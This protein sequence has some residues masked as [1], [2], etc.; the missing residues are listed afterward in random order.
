MVLFKMLLRTY[1]AISENQKVTFEKQTISENQKV[2]F[3]KQ[4]ISENQKVTFEKQTTS[5]KH[6][7]G[8]IVCMYA[9]RTTKTLWL[10][11]AL[12]LFMAFRVLSKCCV[13]RC[14][15]YITQSCDSEL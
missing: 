10:S 3:E 5:S 2:T 4:T 11:E 7:K 1:V 6:V 13:K 14:V 12:A 8:L 9:P 15:L